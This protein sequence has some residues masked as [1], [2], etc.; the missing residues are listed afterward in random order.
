MEGEVLDKIMKIVYESSPK[1]MLAGRL[2]SKLFLEGVRKNLE[3][4]ER[5]LE[6]RNTLILDVGCQ[7]GYITAYLASRGYEV[8]GL[9]VNCP[10]WQKRIWR[11]LASHYGV[12]FVVGDG[13]HLPFRERA[14]GAIISYALIEHIPNSESAVEE[15]NRI[16][17]ANGLFL[18]FE[19]PNKKSY[20]ERLAALIGLWHHQQLYGQTEIHDLLELHG[21]QVKKLESTNV[22]PV[23]LEVWNI[24]YL[25]LLLTYV[26]QI[27]IRTPFKVIAHSFTVISRKTSL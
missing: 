8:I 27:L 11:E 3:E 9:D 26:E 22:L 16:L 2:R 24:G 19:L 25:W 5:Y 10:K 17:S 6:A 1:T 4:V 15:V 7:T 12:S 21:M 23:S 13:K 18:I 14:F 20:T